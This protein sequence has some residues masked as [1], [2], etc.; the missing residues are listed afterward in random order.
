MPGRFNFGQTLPSD[1]GGAAL[2]A[3]VP[4]PAALCLVA[5]TLVPLARRRSL[6]R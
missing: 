1:G 3:L 4:K 6:V 2:G 5:N